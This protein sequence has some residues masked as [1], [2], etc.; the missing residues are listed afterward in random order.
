MSDLAETILEAV[1][2]VARDIGVP[3]VVDAINKA[4]DK[5]QDDEPLGALALGLL[6][7]YID[8]NGADGIDEAID[9]IAD[10]VSGDNPSA[11]FEL[12]LSARDLTDLTDALQDEEAERRER[13]SAG[14]RAF[15]V[16]LGEWLGYI[17]DGL[18]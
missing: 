14:L 17:F 10:A 16:K 8:K 9:A 2:D 5:V 4:K 18:T 11:V 13:V 1:G 15:G 7:T 12:G 6:A 3:F